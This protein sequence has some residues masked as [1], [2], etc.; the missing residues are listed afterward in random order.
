MKVIAILNIALGAGGGF[1]QALNAILQMKRLSVNHFTLEVLTTESVNLAFLEKQQIKASLFSVTR[2]DRFF[3]KM[4]KNGLWVALKRRLTLFSSFEKKL[5][6]QGCDLVYFVI[7]SDLPIVLQKLNYINTLWDLAHR[8]CSEFPEVRERNVYH[9]R[10]DRFRYIL[11]PA[12]VTLTDSEKLGDIAAAYYGVDRSRFLAMPFSP[13]PYFSE[14]RSSP[15]EPVTQKYGM[16]AGYFYYPAQF[17]AHKN[18]IRILQALV[19][20]RKEKNWK[21]TVVFSGKDYGNLAHI[22]RYIKENDL[23]AQVKILGFVPSED[24]R[25]LYE[26]AL[27]IVMPTYFGPTNL[28][29]LEAWLTGTPLLYSAHLSAMT[30]D[31]ALTFDTDSAT[32]LAAAMDHVQNLECRNQLVM[33]GKKRLEEI[34]KERAKSEELLSDLMRRFASRR[35]CWA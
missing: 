32:E 14:T 33:A 18:H 19:H 28:P 17:W 7:P 22:K 25:G 1:D 11:G 15:T 5:M 6:Q 23:E 3:I 12:L 35:Q 16:D 26:N 20:L 2:I 24:M 34:T 30:K 4:A 8:E 31:A 13:S 9:A 10:D 21:P 29:P 27:A